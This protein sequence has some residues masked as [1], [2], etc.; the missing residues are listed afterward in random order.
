MSPEEEAR[1]RIDELLDEAGWVVQDRKAANLYA[2]R[3]VAIREFQM[4]AGHGIA[5]YLLFVDQQPFG[6]IEAKPAG[7]T[8]TGVETQ[9]GKYSQG[10]PPELPKGAWLAT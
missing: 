8:L 10:V 7:H 4:A 6:A 3:G 5:D 9:T 2:G 1:E